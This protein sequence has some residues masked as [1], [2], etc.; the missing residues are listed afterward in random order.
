MRTAFLLVALATLVRVGPETG[1]ASALHGMHYGLAAA[2]WAAAFALWLQGF[3][4]FML[5][6]AL[7]DA[8]D[9]EHRRA[10]PAAEARAGR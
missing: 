7:P 4:P 9:C 3:L 5:A 10:L 6:P 1:L 2:L 8:A